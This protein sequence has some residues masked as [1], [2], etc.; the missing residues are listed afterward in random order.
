MNFSRRAFTTGLAIAPLAPL[1]SKAAQTQPAN[2]SAFHA[3]V[4]DYH[5]M[6]TV[7]VLVELIIPRTDTPGAGDALVHQH[8]DHILSESP[9]A[10][11]VEFLEGL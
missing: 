10:A 9:D 4:F 5:E 3:Q 6:A 1:E 7:E 8:L 2:A 11:R